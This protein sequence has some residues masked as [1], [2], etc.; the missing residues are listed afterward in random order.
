MMDEKPKMT[1]RQ[2]QQEK[3]AQ[4]TI[5]W[6]AKTAKYLIDVVSDVACNRISDRME[7]IMK[8][9]ELKTFSEQNAIVED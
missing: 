5:D 6:A 3:N 1:E 9:Y 8:L 2:R 4:D 7:D